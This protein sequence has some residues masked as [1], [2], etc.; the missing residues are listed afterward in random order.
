MEIRETQTS[1]ENTLIQLVTKLCPELVFL[2]SSSAK[3]DDCKYTLRFGKKERRFFRYQSS[4]KLFVR[5]AL[6]S[7]DE[8]GCVPLFSLGYW[9]DLIISVTAGDFLDCGLRVAKEY[10]STT[11]KKVVIKKLY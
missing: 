7:T 2:G 6:S 3:E 11:E 4:P 10:E 8:G 5:N 9:E 1:L